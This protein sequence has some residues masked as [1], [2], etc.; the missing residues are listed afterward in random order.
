MWL[1]Q[2]G[3]TVCQLCPY[4]YW[5]LPQHRH[6]QTR[7]QAHGG[8][9]PSST[10]SI[11]QSTLPVS[12]PPSQSQSSCL[13][14][15]SLLNTPSG[16]SSIQTSSQPETIDVDD[17]MLRAFGECLDR[18]IG[19]NDVWYKRWLSIVKL[20]GRHYHLPGGSTDRKYIDKLTQELSHFLVEDYPS[21][22]FIVFSSLILQ[23]DL[24]VRKGADI[25]R[26]IERRLSMWNVADYVWPA[27]PGG[28][29]VW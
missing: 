21:E 27:Y 9:L 13:S 3:Q 25:R 1:C 19:S 16:E 18:S 4:P 20:S 26:V 2:E 8:R 24:T 28:W 14:S 11:T 5:Y 7:H 6:T 17:L 12:S 10:C 29:K 22:R 23:Q 15:P